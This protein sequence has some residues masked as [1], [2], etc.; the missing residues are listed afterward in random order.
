MV[1]NLKWATAHLSRRLG[2]GLGARH[3]DTARGRAGWARGTQVGAG[4]GT[5]VGAGLGAQVGA[6]RACVVGVQGRAR[7]RLGVLD[8]RAVGAG[9]RRAAARAAGAGMG[10]RG[11]G[12]ER[13]ECAAWARGAR[14]LG[15]PM[16]AGWACWLV[17][18]ASFGA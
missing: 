18:W 3:S 12:R 2:A 7:A 9:A 4:L 8:A 16:R 14:G 5:Q 11:A 17:S 6:G 1:Q 15:L 10:A 13:A